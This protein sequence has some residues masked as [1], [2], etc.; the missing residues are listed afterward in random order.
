MCDFSF[1][2][3]SHVYTR[4]FINLDLGLFAR[5]KCSLSKYTFTLF[6][7]GL[8]LKAKENLLVLMNKVTLES[9]IYM[10]ICTSTTLEC[11]LLK[12]NTTSFNLFY[13]VR[14]GSKPFFSP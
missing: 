1:T 14:L 8:K 9:K 7:V 4:T 6:E 10:Q 11:Y 2:H 3:V 5:P 12:Q 13:T